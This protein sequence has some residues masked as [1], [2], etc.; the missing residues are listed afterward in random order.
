M[1]IPRWGDGMFKQVKRLRLTAMQADD[2]ASEDGESGNILVMFACSL[3][4]LIFFIGLAVD[5]SMVLWQKGQLVNDAQLIKDNRFV[6]QDAVRYADDPGEK[7]EEKALQTLKSN[8]YSGKGK[9]YFREY[10]PRNVRERKVKIRVELNKE[11]DT[12]FFQVFGIKHIPISTSIDFEDTYGDYRKKSS[13]PVKEVNRVWHP[14]K[15]VS[16]YNGT[17]A[18]DS[19]SDTPGRTNPK[20]PSGF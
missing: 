8:N 15:S 1:S 10:E 20:L 14:Q 19:T 9:I 6:Y 12:Y 4:V 5:V 18:F 16:E 2:G 11:A 7:F 13:D 3:F 17:Y